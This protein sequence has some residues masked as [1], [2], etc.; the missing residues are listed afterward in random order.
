MRH[1]PATVATV[2]YKLVFNV[3]T[4]KHMAMGHLQSPPELR[5]HLI[6][7]PPFDSIILHVCGHWLQ[8]ASL[9]SIS[10]YT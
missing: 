9:S 3:S 6:G 4:F 10:G 1:M 8:S 2:T 7:G 5:E